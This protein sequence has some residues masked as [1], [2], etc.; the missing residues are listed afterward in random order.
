[1]R[2]GRFAL[3]FALAATLC[4]QAIKYSYDAAGRLSTVSY[5]NGKTAT[6]FYD[7]GGSLISRQVITAGSGAPPS[8]SAAGV[9]NA[10]S[11]A[12]GSVAPGEI[13]AIYGSGVGPA[14]LASFQISQASFFQPFIAGTTVTFDGI[15]AP[16]VFA[17]SGLVAAIVPYSVAGQST[18]QMVVT[19][20]GQASSPVTLQVAPSAPGLFSANGSGTGNGAIVNQD[21][22]INS[23]S[24]PAPRGS[25]ILLY[26][27][28][29]GQTTPAG[30]DGRIALSVYPKPALP[31]KVSL[32]GTD[33]TSNILYVGAAPTLVAG[34]FQMN[35]TIP[36]NAPT[37]AVP[38]VVTVGT[39]SSQ[40][41]LTVAVK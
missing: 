22:T 30:V 40:S 21:G 27:T 15:P 18:T 36:A 2:H 12:G 9:V 28:G 6:Y 26:G 39:A 3:P 41:G 20:Q 33:V 7:A 34:V 17:S 16:L 24:N 35:L 31:V 8:S 10:A 5:P 1:V 13:V 14:T 37:G 4:G 29:E 19:C 11:E 32:G 23:P 38:V 25:V